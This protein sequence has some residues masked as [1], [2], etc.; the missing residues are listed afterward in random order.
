MQ[1]GQADSHAN[2]EPVLALLAAQDFQVINLGLEL[3]AETLV[4]LGFKVVHVDWRPPASGDLELTDILA[5]LG[6][7]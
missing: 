7:S 4:E 6:R 5:A 3:F 1:A 2:I